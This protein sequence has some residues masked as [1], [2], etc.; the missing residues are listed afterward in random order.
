MK[1]KLKLLNST[2]IEGYPSGSAMEFYANRIYLA[3]DNAT[4]AGGG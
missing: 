4:D 3:G 2:E 1:M